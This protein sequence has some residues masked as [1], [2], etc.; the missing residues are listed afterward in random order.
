MVKLQL[1]SRRKGKIRRYL[2]DPL[3]QFKETMNDR[4]GIIGFFILSAFILVAIL[5]SW[6]A[7]YHPFETTYLPDGGVAKLTPPS[8]LYWLGTTNMGEDILSQILFGSRS[9]L[10]IGFI[11]AACITI[12]GTNIGLIA[13]YFGGKL[14][15]LLMRLTDIAFGIPLIPF[16]IVLV[17]ILGTSK[18]NIIIAISV[19]LW[20]T[21]ARVIR[22]QVLSL[23]ERPFI[24]S[25]RASGAGNLRIVYRHIAPNILNL[26]FLYIPLGIG[27]AVG[28]EASLSFVGLGDPATISWGR[29]LYF[30]FYA[31]AIRT[32]WWWV[33]PPGLCI[34]FFVASC[35]VIARAYE[36]VVHPKFREM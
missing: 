35:Y 17:A 1:Q 4:L 30:A 24:F 28:A 23:K 33:L 6:I 25:A 32:A 20:R 16:G 34:G 22:S 3:M 15:D 29:M 36:R 12:I 19:L 11:S 5:S 2:T 18:W 8:R 21:T 14:D 31:G 9:V 26:A 10:I 7:P 13:G 27:W